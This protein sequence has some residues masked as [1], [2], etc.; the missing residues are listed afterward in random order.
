MIASMETWIIADEAASRI[1]FKRNFR[2]GQIPQ[3]PN[4]E[5]VPKESVYQVL[6]AATSDRYEKGRKSFELLG[7]LDPLIVELKC[8]AAKLLLDRLRGLA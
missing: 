3:W 8:G 4:L 6:K 2:D 1:F 7:S 5:K